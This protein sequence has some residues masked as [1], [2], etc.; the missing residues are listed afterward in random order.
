[1]ERFK[2][3]DESAGTSSRL[4]LWILKA[5]VE[6][7]EQLQRMR[8]MDEE[9][10]HRIIDRTT[11]DYG[12]AKRLSRRELAVFEAELRTSWREFARGRARPMPGS[13]PEDAG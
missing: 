9:T 12:A 10:F 8:S 13:P 7:W 11:A 6:V 5:K 3:T 1:M 4:N 2:K